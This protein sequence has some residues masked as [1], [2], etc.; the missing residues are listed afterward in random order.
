MSQPPVAPKHPTVHREHGVERVDDYHWLLDKSSE[1][2]LS[3]LRAERAYYDAEMK[4]LASLIE[5]LTEEMVRRVPQTEE[6]AR[7]REGSYEYFT[8]VPEGREFA[9]LFRVGADG[10]ES[11]VLDQN[12]L[13]EDS[14]YVEVGV[15]LV[16]PNGDLLAYSVDVAGDE[17]YELRFRDLTTGKD[18]PDRVPHTYYGGGWAADGNDFFYVVHD[19]KYRPFQ[20]WRHRLGTAAGDDVKVYE[21]SD[22]QF[23]V[24]CWAD[25]AGDLLVVFAYSTNT[26]EAWL[27]DAHLPDQPAW[28]VTAREHGIDY[29]LA[30]RPGPDGGD[31]LIVT[32]HGHAPERR[33]MAAPRTS[34]VRSEWRQ[35]IAE[36]P[37]VRIQDVEVFARHV[38]LPTVSDGRQQLR[39]FSRDKLSDALTIDD[40]EILEAEIP[41]G[42]LVLWHNEEPDVDSVLVQVDSYTNPGEWVQIHLD[43][44][45]R[46]VVRKRRLPNY[47]ES[48]YVTELRSI[49]ARD[50]ESIPLKIARRR[51]TALDGTAP[52]LL[53]GYG[54]YESAFW[55]GFEGSLPSLLDRGVVFVHALI[56]GGGEKGRRWY[57]GGQMLTKRNTFTDFIDVADALAQEGL[58]DGSRIVSRGLSAG[59]LLQGAVYSMRP[60]RWRAVVAEVPFV[61]VVTTMLNHDIPLTSQEVEEWGDPRIAEQ[62]EYML[63]YSP[64]DNVPVGDRPELL[65]TGALHDPRV[66]IHEPAKWVAK[67][68]STAQP[69]D[70][71]TLFRAEL[72]EGGHSGPPGRFAHLAYEAE[73]AA[74]ILQAVTSQTHTDV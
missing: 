64:Y 5:T 59:G 27:V 39:V 15:R 47:D 21:E 24:T 23:F 19:E 46:E 6:S 42:L 44:G 43:S 7:W 3:Y 18:L 26:S 9:Q 22:E 17:V 13:L 52:M 69:G 74:F 34:S 38:V 54:A 30:H 35:L 65:A 45:A 8:R 14:S 1:E 71:R 10:V 40:G 60:D 63:G 4:P 55:P 25:R 49:A 32:N 62:F 67:I 70:A 11:L 28:V 72:G 37:N 73:V 12:E 20:V 58:I 29:R 66:S 50:G 53:Y 36:S 16:S 57:L 48:E 2:S 41:G 33:L 51:D 61:D 68:R 31:L 56:R